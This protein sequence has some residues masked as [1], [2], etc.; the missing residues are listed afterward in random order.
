M[1]QAFIGSEA[2]AGGLSRGES[3][4]SARVYRD[5]YVPDGTEITAVVRAQA[6]WLWSRRRAVIG[7]LA[8]AAL[9]GSKWVDPGL[10]VD[11]YYDNRHRLPG[12]NPRAEQLG[13]DEICTAAGVPVTTPARTALDLACWHPLVRRGGLRR[14][15]GPSHGC[16]D[17][18]NR[19]ARRTSARA[20]R[21]HAGPEGDRTRRRRCAVA[22][23]VMASHLASRG[24]TAQA[25]D[26]DSPSVTDSARRRVPGHGVSGF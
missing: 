2:I 8:A 1:I 22:E 11:L 15:L 10:S 5:V 17:S 18:R 25:A 6:A 7:G 3:A 9:H 16:D 13:D 26:T 4:G 20:A 19:V 23:G 12:L 24:R 21:N 14:R